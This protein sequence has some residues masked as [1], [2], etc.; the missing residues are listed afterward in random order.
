MSTNLSKYDPPPSHQ[1]SLEMAFCLLQWMMK[2][3]IVFLPNSRTLSR[4]W[5]LVQ[6]VA[7]HHVEEKKALVRPAEHNSEAAQ[8]SQTAGV[9]TWL[10]CCAH[11]SWVHQLV[12]AVRSCSSKLVTLPGISEIVST[13]IIRTIIA[14]SAFES[15]LLVCLVILGAVVMTSQISTA[16]MKNS[17]IENCSNWY[18]HDTG[19]HPS[20]SFSCCWA[21]HLRCT[22]GNVF[23][24]DTPDSCFSSQS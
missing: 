6:T 11:G 12:P 4:D 22:P 24:T 14:L 21:C 8:P 19:Q 17:Y 13:I 9:P 16:P 20:N 3:S 5:I 7:Q 1:K 18:C 10:G 23:R 2:D 15:P